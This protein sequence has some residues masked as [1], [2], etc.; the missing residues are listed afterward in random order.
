[1]LALAIAAGVTATHAE[2]TPYLVD[3]A[4][5]PRIVCV[6]SGT[7]SIGSGVRISAELVVTAAHVVDEGAACTVDGAAATLERADRGKDIVLLRVATPA[8]LRAIVGCGAIREGASYLGAGYAE[9]FDM[10]RVQALTGTSARDPGD[11]GAALKGMV[12]FRG[13][14]T[15]GMSGGGIFDERTGAAVGIINV[16]YDNGILR[17]LGR[18]FADTFVCERKDPN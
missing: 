9:G 5:V 12:V 6:R 8:P 2:P 13:T 3:E 1:M 18:S 15:P 16:Y 14:A 10:L 4:V 11:Q 7:A 17:M